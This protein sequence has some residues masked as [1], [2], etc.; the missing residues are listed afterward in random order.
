MATFLELGEK[1]F[2][3]RTL[4]GTINPGKTEKR[5]FV[6]LHFRIAELCQRVVRNALVGTRR[7]AGRGRAQSDYGSNRCTRSQDRPYFQHDGSN[8]A[9]LRRSNRRSC[10]LRRRDSTYLRSLCSRGS[11]RS[12]QLFLVSALIW[13]LR[14]GLRVTGLC[15][16]ILFSGRLRLCP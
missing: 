9:L 10:R 2:D 15:P 4:P 16:R 3:L 8:P 12:L 14:L 1:S 13:R 11:D 6:K 5:E 7:L